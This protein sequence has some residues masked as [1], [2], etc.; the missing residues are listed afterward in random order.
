MNKKMSELDLRL[1]QLLQSCQLTHLAFYDRDRAKMF[2]AETP[3]PPEDFPAEPG[4][5]RLEHDGRQLFYI[6][7][8][9]APDF[10]E[11][12][13]GALI[14]TVVR[15]PSGA[16]LYHSVAADFHLCC[17]TRQ[18]RITEL[19]ARMNEGMDGLRPAVRYSMLHRRAYA[20][21]YAAAG[22]SAKPPAGE[23]DTEADDVAE[24]NPYM[25]DTGADRAAGIGDLLRAALGIHGLHYVAYY[26]AGVPACTADIFRHPALRSHF[27]SAT[28]QQR[29]DRYGLLGQLLPGVTDRMNTSLHALLEG[30]IQQIVLNVEQGAVYFQQLYDRHYL[31][32]VSLNQARLAEAD[33]HI[34]RLGRELAD[35]A[36]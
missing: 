3:R 30:E 27:G 10:A 18:D 17:A 36:G 14:R 23:D 1:R 15:V 29:R 28:P 6:L 25:V 31:L 4:S 2:A 32:G 8:E 33:Q 13:T 5:E 11:L 12:R 34:E 26:A 35:E 22:A 9:L 16:L 24:G 21:R 7:E 20:S 19:I